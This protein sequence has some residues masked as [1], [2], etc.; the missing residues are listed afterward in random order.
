MVYIFK[1]LDLPKACGALICCTVRTDIEEP[2]DTD[3]ALSLSLFV[4]LFPNTSCGY[5]LH[6]SALW[7]HPVV[8]PSN[9]RYFGECEDV[10]KLAREGKGGFE[11]RRI[12]VSHQ[13][14]DQAMDTDLEQGAGIQLTVEVVC[15]AFWQ[16]W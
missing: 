4:W 12:Q 6:T 10:G 11:G 1:I 2:P 16:D 8:F 7:W 14:T 5:G 15:L 3:E 9:S 13:D